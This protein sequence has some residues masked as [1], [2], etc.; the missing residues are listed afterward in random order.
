[1]TD[2]QNGPVD[3]LSFGAAAATYDTYRPTYP[4]EALT[5]A[6][7]SAPLRVVDLGAGTGIM[8]R[9]LLAL[10]H[11]VIPVEPDERMRGQ[12]AETTPGVAP[13]AGAGEDIPLPDASVDAVVCGQSY[14]WFDRD[15][16]HPEIARVLRPGGVLAPVWNLRDDDVPWIAE[17]TRIAHGPSS[18]GYVGDEH[19]D[20]FGPLFTVPELEIF[21]HTIPMITEDLLALVTTRS[22]YLVAAP[23]RQRATTDAI[24]ALVADLPQPFD[25][26]Y[27]TKTYRAWTV[28]A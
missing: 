27:L 18:R 20:S 7:G 16:A 21:R 11:E 28:T 17:F 4:A 24:R 2:D 19:I 1:V 26:P 10:G 9:V 22:Y 8:T 14:H 3:R 23:E 6:L 13:L 15:K 25:V 5:W 12:L